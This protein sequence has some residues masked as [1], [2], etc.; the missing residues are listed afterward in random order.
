MMIGC[1]AA[2]IGPDGE[3]VVVYPVVVQGDG[4]SSILSEHFQ[5][6]VAER[7]T[8]P[9]PSLIPKPAELTFAECACLPTA[10]LTA[11]RMLT[12]KARLTAGDSV[13]VQGAG[14]GVATAA[15]VL[16]GALG[17]RAYATSR[18]A[19]KRARAESLGAQAFEPGARLPERVDAVIET[20]GQATFDH[21]MKSTKMGGRIVV[22]G[23]T[24]GHLPEVNLRR[25]FALQLEIL[26]TSMGTPDELGS[27]LDLLAKTGV[28]PVIDSVHPFSDARKAFERLH[29][30]EVFGKVVIDHTA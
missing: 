19:A 16:A 20:V 17:I 14:G 9:A 24:S 2:G 18:D 3:E 6:T 23:A 15:V 29:S 11:Y 12:T 4:S 26:G 10:W 7:V 28:R 21:S 8:V 13:L 1:D 27:L 22:S 30:G 25:V 5:G